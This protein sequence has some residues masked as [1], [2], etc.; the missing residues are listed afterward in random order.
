M[1]I[2]FFARRFYPL[3]GGVEKHVFEISSH[4]IQKGHRVIVVTEQTGNEDQTELLPVKG[5][6][7]YIEIH[8]IPT[9]TNERLKKFQIWSALWKLRKLIFSADI[10]HCHD[11][12]FWYLPFRF[13][14]RHK[15]VFITFHGYESFPI[16]R[17]AIFV[18]KIS[19]KLT[20]GNICIGD[21]I[22]KYY[23][24]IPDFISYGAVTVSELKSSRKIKTDSA[25]FI[26]RLDEQ[27]SILTYAKSIS[28]IQNR[29]KSFKFLVVGEGKYKRYIANRFKVI[30]FQRDIHAYLANSHYA[31]ISRYLGILEAFA[32]RR[33]V[34][35][36]FDNPVKEDYLK[37]SPF[38]PFMVITNNPKDLSDKLHYYRKHPEEESILIEEAYSWVQEQ[39]W[40]KMVTTY[41]DLWKK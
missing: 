2:L 32:A 18:R 20:K 8:R 3:I 28:L 15:P 17:K 25:V 34:F 12:F 4:L 1:T 22:A 10:V 7:T 39:T 41:L 21:F 16:K 27:T 23:G 33:L 14:Y 31:F 29:Y 6:K 11:V 35:A 24:T 40:E 5:K 13:I 38:A 19:E 26:G 36:V 37:L 30:G 9:G